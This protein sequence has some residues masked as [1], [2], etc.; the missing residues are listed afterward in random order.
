M[1]KIAELEVNQLIEDLILV[2]K[3]ATARE[4]K[5]KKPYLVLELYDGTDTISG[6]YWDWESGNIPPVNT[7]LDITAQVTEWQGSKQL[8]IKAMRNNTTKH[9][10]EFAPD[11]GH[12]LASTYKEAYTLANQI[13]DDMLQNL[14][15]TLLEE[16]R[17]LWLEVPGARSMHHAYIGGTL[18]HSL[19]VA[20]IAKSI[21]ANIPE[22]NEDLCVVGAL[23]HDI[24]KLYTYRLNGVSIDMTDDGMLYDHIFMGAEF[25]G[26]FA[27]AHIDGDDYIN[28]KKMQLLR[29][30]ILAHHGSLE[31]GSPVTPMCIEA[32]IVH[33]AD[34]IDAA[35]E[36]IRAAAKKVPDNVKWTERIYAMNNRPQLTPAYVN[37]IMNEASEEKVGV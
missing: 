22:A 21:A 14:V 15:L 30:I 10:A 16:L 11:S 1:M 7:I 37:Y 18:V 35:T 3:S 23:L 12:D 8:N 28:M 13:K 17:S 31:Y 9:L 24:G 4:T 27:D 19:S 33:C 32:H 5:A 25:I 29:H 6:N 20:K 34:G 36:Q 26:N 2:V